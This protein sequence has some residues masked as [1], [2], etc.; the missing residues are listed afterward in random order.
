MNGRSILLL[1]S[2]AVPLEN[3]P[4]VLENFHKLSCKQKKGNA[5]YLYLFIEE[6]SIFKN[7][8]KMFSPMQIIVHF[9]F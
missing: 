4:V 5:C 7:G 9:V 1:F 3:S 6:D 2:E 8:F